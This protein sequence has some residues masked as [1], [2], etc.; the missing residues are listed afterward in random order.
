MK[1]TK[2]NGVIRIIGDIAGYVG[3]ISTHQSVNAINVFSDAYYLERYKDCIFIYPTK[4]KY[5][6]YLQAFRASI[7][8]TKIIMTL[9]DVEIRKG[10]LKIKQLE[11][12]IE[13]IR[14]GQLKIKQLEKVIEESTKAIEETT[15]KIQELEGFENIM[16]EDKN[17]K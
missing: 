11:K 8:V 10:Q 14:K 13:E 2:E 1:K 7:K 9:N 6:K 12:V 16:S 5:F 3:V 17:D 4:G 15:V